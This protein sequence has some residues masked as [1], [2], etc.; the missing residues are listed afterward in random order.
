[1]QKCGT[2]CHSM[3][4]IQAQALV[5]I[6]LVPGRA[7]ALCHAVLHPLPRTV[8]TKQS[9]MPRYATAWPWSAD[10]KR[11]TLPETRLVRRDRRAG[12]AGA[13]AAPRIPGLGCCLQHGTCMSCYPSPAPLSSKTSTSL[14]LTCV[15]VLGPRPP[16]HLQPPPH[17]VKWIGQ[18]LR[19]GQQRQKW[20]CY[21][22][23]ATDC[24]SY[25]QQPHSCTA[26]PSSTSAHRR[27]TPSRRVAEQSC[28][29]VLQCALAPCCFDRQLPPCA[30]ASCCVID[31]CRHVHP[32][33]PG[34]LLPRRSPA[35][36]RCSGR[37]RPAA[38]QSVQGRCWAVQKPG[39]LLHTASSQV[40]PG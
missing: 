2:R 18:R 30:L 11:Q 15:Q 10:S 6:S 36:L 20:F 1:M 39:W 34:C 22:Y 19:G 12:M 13:S 23:L 27:L 9:I 33:D 4:R 35:A 5:L 3:R 21:L 26:I 16:R 32:P 7:I 25:R 17:H 8:R 31:S 40:A 37:A 24:C 28:R 14:P 29:R 38:L